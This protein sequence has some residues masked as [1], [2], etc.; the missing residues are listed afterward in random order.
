MT[1]EKWA[2]TTAGKMGLKSAESWVL[3]MV[4]QTVAYLVGLKATT[5]VEKMAERTAE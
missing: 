5:K 2:A 4:E 3:L 1:V